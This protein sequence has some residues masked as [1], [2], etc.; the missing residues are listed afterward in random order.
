M[1][2]LI[3]TRRNGEMGEECHSV[4]NNYK[5]VEIEEYF[6]K[7]TYKDA[8]KEWFGTSDLDKNLWELKV[9]DKTGKLYVKAI[10][11]WMTMDI[12]VVPLKYYGDYDKQKLDSLSI[13]A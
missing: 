6:S 8:I 3:Y 10:D 13:N 7:K 9:F 5:I 4:Y 1:Q 2:Y 11:Y 12:M